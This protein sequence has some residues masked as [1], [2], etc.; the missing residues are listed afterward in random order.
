LSSAAGPWGSIGWSYD[1]V[2]NRLTQTD[3]S[4]TATYNYQ[5]GSNRLSGISGAQ[6]A[7]Y[8]L[9]AN[10]NTTAES[11]NGYTYNQNQRLK[12]A[13]AS[14]SA[15]YQYNA[16]GQRAIKI[17]SGQVTIYHYDQSGQLIAETDA[18]GALQA[19]YLYLD[20]Q[21]LAKIDAT[22]I[23]YIHPDHLGT[24]QLVTDSQGTVVW[25]IEARPFGDSPTIT[26]TQS[27]NLRFPGQYFDA[28][29]GL[30]QNWFRDYQPNLGRYVE[31]D[32]IGLRG[33]GLFVYGNSTP[34]QNYDSNGLFPKVAMEHYSRAYNPHT[35]KGG[36]SDPGIWIGGDATV[37]GNAVLFGGAA[38][39]GSLT[40]VSTGETC[41]YKMVCGKVGLGIIL[42]AGTKVSISMTGPHCGKNLDGYNFSIAVEVVV[43]VPGAGFG[44]NIGYGG[45]V[46]GGVSVGPE[47]GAGFF[48]GVDICKIEVIECKFS[49]EDCRGCN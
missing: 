49:P 25:Q 2:G 12:H 13:A 42:S 44:G 14:Q 28:E 41:F 38:G 34:S 23:S 3:S 33:G 39:A 46:G 19:E 11:S 30:H 26:G 4:G 20:G 45:G 24:P 8:T 32:P 22:G 48:F 5:S 6:S 40:N 17:V 21:P 9:D 7:S 43:P 47:G 10:G 15:D 37:G 35:Y 16:Q 18:S 36:G 31:A 29:S 27:L 1:P